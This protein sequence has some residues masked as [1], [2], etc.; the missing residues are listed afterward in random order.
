MINS[1]FEYDVENVTVML[2]VDPSLDAFQS[3]P[4]KYLKSITS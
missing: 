3:H 1:L 2:N 4:D